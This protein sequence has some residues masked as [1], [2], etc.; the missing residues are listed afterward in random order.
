MNP[1]HLH[2][3]V[4]HFPL[5]S[6]ILG[7]LVI[8]SGLILRSETVKRTAY[9]IFIFAAAMALAAFLT[10]DGAEQAIVNVAGVEENYIHTHEEMAETFAILCYILGAFSI[11][12]LWASLQRHAISSFVVLM[13]TVFSVLVINFGVKAGT[14]GGEIRHSEIRQEQLIP[15]ST[16]SDKNEND[17]D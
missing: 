13:C 9:C 7:F 2:L 8:L 6:L 11:L 4:N 16:N 10:G 3:I 5:I 14:S 17:R 1:A 12:G 15:G